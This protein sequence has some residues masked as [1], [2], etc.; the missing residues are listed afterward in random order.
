MSVGDYHMGATVALRPIQDTTS[1]SPALNL[2]CQR[3]ECGKRI[4]TVRLAGTM[5]PAFSCQKWYAEYCSQLL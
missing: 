5:T 2:M 1:G 4:E 3:A